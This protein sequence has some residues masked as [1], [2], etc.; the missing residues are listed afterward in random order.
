LF[1]STAAAEQPI[2]ATVAPR[3]VP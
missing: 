1:D 2:T 3:S